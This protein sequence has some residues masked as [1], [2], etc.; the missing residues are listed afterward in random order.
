LLCP[1]KEV[2]DDM[3]RNCNSSHLECAERVL[4]KLLHP[5]TEKE[6]LEKKDKFRQEFRE[7]RGKTGAFDESKLMWGSSLLDEGKAHVWHDTYSALNTDVLGWLGCRVTSKILGIGNAE[8]AWGAVKQLMQ[9]KRGAISGSRIKKQATIYAKS[10]IDEAMIKSQHIDDSNETFVN[11]TDE[12]IAFI[13]G[14][15]ISTEDAREYQ[16][17]PIFC[18]WQEPWE[19]DVRKK[20]DPVNQAKLQTKYVGIQ[21]YDIDDETNDR[22]VVGETIVYQKKEGYLVNCKISIDGDPEEDEQWYTRTMLECIADDRSRHLN[23]HVRVIYTQEEDKTTVT[24]PAK[25]AARRMDTV[26]SSSDEEDTVRKR[27]KQLFGGDN[28]KHRKTKR[29]RGEKKGNPK[30]TGESD[31]ETNKTGYRNKVRQNPHEESESDSEVS[32]KVVKPPPRNISMVDLCNVQSDDGAPSDMDISGEGKNSRETS[33]KEKE[34]ENEEEVELFGDSESENGIDEEKTE[35][36]K[37]E[38]T[39]NT[40]TKESSNK[41]NEISEKQRKDHVLFNNLVLT[42]RGYPFSREELLE[43]DRETGKKFMPLQ[44]VLH[45]IQK[46]M[47]NPEEL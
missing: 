7:F 23:S 41:S 26:P 17:R 35:T 27:R 31:D 2:H 24:S 43:K 22:L 28:S 40:T 39:S 14:A 1:I 29:R 9:G 6:K 36:N 33:T 4:E 46:S 10:C 25:A 5:A 19:I 21:F 13:K 16:R 8:R 38:N 45:R 3:S 44:E 20:R 34:K 47:E 15:G 37:Q 12:D 11:W 30:T 18:C 32:V 42:I